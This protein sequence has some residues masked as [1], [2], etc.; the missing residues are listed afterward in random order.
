MFMRIALAIVLSGLAAP[1]I[2]GPK[3]DKVI[4]AAQ[5]W[6]DCVSANA[7]RW[8]DTGEA[9]P[10]IVTAAFG[11]C[12]AE[13]GA[14]RAALTNASRDTFGLGAPAPA[15]D[16]ERAMAQVRTMIEQRATAT[17]LDARTGAK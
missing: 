3:Q 8:I 6:S 14:F 5:A 10:T 16:I 7:L 11:R 2:A 1:A 13:D 4:A 12:T 9:T 15:S 17:I